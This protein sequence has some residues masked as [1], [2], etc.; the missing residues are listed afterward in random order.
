VGFSL[1][2]IVLL[3]LVGII[4]V[5]PKNLPSMMR[6]AGQWVARL[7]RM[8]TD[9]R[10]QSGIDDLLRQEGLEQHIHELRSLSRLN[11]VDTLMAPAAA[12][13]PLD[14]PAVR[15]VPP[16]PPPSASNAREPMREREYP[17]AGCDACGA[18]PDDA[19]VRAV[20]AG[21]P[22]PAVTTEATTELTMDPYAHAG[23]EAFHDGPEP[24][25]PPAP[26]GT[27]EPEVAAS[28][29]LQGPS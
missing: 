29:T 26:A 19:P 17:L 20:A 28:A 16:K 8:S 2:E 3:I 18:L 23:D 10:S 7:K 11:V 14:T 24:P 13:R 22:A 5:G 1:G 6:T 9:L 12:A 15:P 21:A 27:T 4:V 25:A